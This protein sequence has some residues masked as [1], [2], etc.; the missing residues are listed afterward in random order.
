MKITRIAVMS[1]ILIGLTSCH[2]DT[3]YD[4]VS[5]S[6][7]QF[8]IEDGVMYDAPSS[9]DLIHILFY[10]PVSG[11]KVDETYTPL[12]GGYIYPYH[13]G[14]TYDIIAYAMGSA[15]TNVTYVNSI[16]L[17]TAESTTIDYSVD[18]VNTAPSHLFLACRQGVTIPHRSVMDEEWVLNLRL[19]SICEEWKIVVSGVKGLQYTSAIEFTI[20]N[21]VDEVLLKDI[22][23]NG[24]CKLNI[25]A[26]KGSNIIGDRIEASFQTFGMRRDATIT[27]Q[28]RLTAEDG[29]IHVLKKDIT[30]QVTDPSNSKHLIL[31]DFDTTLSPYVQGGLDPRAEEWDDNKE[32]IEI[33]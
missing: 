19:K 7:I 14:K 10:D 22:I 9:I 17:L 20:N 21:Q 24:T 6:K 11:K 15:K 33:E 27:L 8:E 1:A 29:Q 25:R 30:S 28:T 4:P 2:R 16:D 32:K 23:Q 5:Q 26:N 12:S 31:V 18:K 13:Q 3:V